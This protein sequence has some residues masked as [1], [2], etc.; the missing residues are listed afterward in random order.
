MA[1]PLRLSKV[2][3]QTDL[4]SVR[5]LILDEAD[6][7]FEEGLFKQTDRVIKACSH[8][9]LVRYHGTTIAG[10][11]E[12]NKLQCSGCVWGARAN[13]CTMQFALFMQYHVHYLCPCN[14]HLQC[15]QSY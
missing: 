13:D 1:T 4:S 2:A 15:G 14:L 8:P 6:K 10:V 3:K 11:C 7:L 12:S 5:Y 9:R